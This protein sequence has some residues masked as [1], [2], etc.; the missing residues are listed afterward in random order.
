MRVSREAGF[1]AKMKTGM[2]FSPHYLSGLFD[3]MVFDVVEQVSRVPSGYRLEA[4][5]V[6]YGDEGLV[7]FRWR[8]QD[9]R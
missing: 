9:A 6:E 5:W 7:E 2:W 1:E 4:R 3:F 8:E